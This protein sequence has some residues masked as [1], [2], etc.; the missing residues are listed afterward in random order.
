M[1]EIVRLDHDAARR[2]LTARLLC[3]L[4]HHAAKEAREEI[5]RAFRETA[6]DLLALDFS[7]VSFMDSSGVGLIL[8]RLSLCAAAGARMEI[9][10]VSQATLRLLR[11]AGLQR[12]P[13][14]KIRAA[15]DDGR[16]N[17]ILRQESRREEER[18]ARS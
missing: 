9:V 7:G 4:D 2:T 5:D 11:M 10:G 8:G 18:I 6:P 16:Q 13:G 3:E 17:E 15:E 1:T 14:L 12:M